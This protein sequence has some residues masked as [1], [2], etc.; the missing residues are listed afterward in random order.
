MTSAVHATDVCIVTT[1]WVSHKIVLEM[2]S[3]VL[4][5][6]C[7]ICGFCYAPAYSNPLL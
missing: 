1:P 2:Q 6:F 7:L 4:I 5:S 3:T